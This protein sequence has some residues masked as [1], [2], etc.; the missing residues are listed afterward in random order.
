M[1]LETLKTAL[2]DYAKDLK[3]NLQS[4]AIDETLNKTRRAGAFIASALASRNAIVT[5]AI[6]GAFADDLSAEELKAAETAAALMAMTNIYY[7][8]T[9]LMSA[10]EYGSAPAKLRVNAL[11]NP[12]APKEDFDLWAVAVSAINGCGAC[13][14]SH[15]RT[16]R[17]HN[18]PPE[19]VQTALRIAAVVHAIAAVLDGE[20]AKLQFRAAA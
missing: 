2:P 11:A 13:L 18:V 15:E 16:L 17:Q 8:A 12:G 20:V 7:R 1:S 14:D 5:T 9:H 4:L 6:Y 19:Q 10:P 3:L